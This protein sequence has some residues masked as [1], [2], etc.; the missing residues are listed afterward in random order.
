V[1]DRSR[2][3]VHRSGRGRRVRWSWH[4]A[5]L[6]RSGCRR[7]GRRLGGRWCNRARPRRPARRALLGRRRRLGTVNGRGRAAGGDRSA[8]LVG[9]LGVR[10]GSDCDGRR[11]RDRDDCFHAATRGVLLAPLVATAPLTLAHLGDPRGSG[12]RDRAH[13]CACSR[14]PAT[15]RPAS[16]ISGRPPRPALPGDR[17]LRMWFQAGALAN[18]PARKVS[19]FSQGAAARGRSR[20]GGKLSRESKPDESGS[21]R[22]D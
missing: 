7:R 14:I 10:G 19:A 17:P 11:D 9:L 16:S 18:A 8:G 20:P 12:A 2:R 6:E 1:H 4:R 5:L 21:N 22:G 3:R 15:P 13:L